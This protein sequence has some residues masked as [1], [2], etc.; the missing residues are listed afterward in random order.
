VDNDYVVGNFSGLNRLG[1]SRKGC[2]EKKDN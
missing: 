1:E 2:S